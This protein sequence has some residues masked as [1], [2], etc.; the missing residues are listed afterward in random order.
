MKET[1]LEMTKYVLEFIDPKY[2]NIR[3]GV[4]TNMP[5]IIEH[6]AHTILTRGI[7][8]GK[9]QG[10]EQGI[11]IGKEQGM[12]QGIELGKE[13]GRQE[14]RK[15]MT[16]EVNHQRESFAKEMIR[17]KIDLIKVSRYSGLPLYQVQDL[18]A[19]IK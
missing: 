12:E 4:E 13:L 1:L 16:I 6:E 8:I 11:E 17:D 5:R 14:E 15:A 18:A 9:E 10:M 19:N 2:P 7:E 3:K